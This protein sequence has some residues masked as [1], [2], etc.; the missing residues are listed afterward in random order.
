MNTNLQDVIQ[1]FA[2]LGVTAFGGPAAHIAMMRQEVVSKRQ[3][4]GDQEFLNLVGATNLIPGPNSTELAIHI[5][6]K[7]AGWKGLL[8]AG[9]FFRLPA[10]L[11]TG[12]IAWI[13]KKYGNLP[14]VEPFIYG[15]KPAIIAIILM[16]VYPLA[17]TAIKNAELAIV[18]V[19]AL[20]LAL[21]G[22]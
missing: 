1:L 9:A 14:Q 6:Q 2:R 22:L 10:V 11:I 8:A 5:G 21:A 4:M 12:I 20:L 19:V 16:A 13:Y 18:A 15:I 7:R 17:K 3:W